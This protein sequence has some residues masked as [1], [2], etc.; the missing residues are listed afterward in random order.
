MRH[1][2]LC[3][4]LAFVQLSLIAPAMGQDEEP[5][6]AQEESKPKDIPYLSGMPDFEITEN[7]DIEFDSYQ[8]FDGKNIVP[9]EGRLYKRTY[10]LKDGAPGVSELQIRRNYISA[11]K[12]MG[13]AI[14]YEG[15]CE[16][17]NDTRS[18][19]TLVWGKV[20]RNSDELWVEVYP[21]GGGSG[22]SYSLAVL[23]KETMKQD[24]TANDMF[25]ALNTDGHIAL[26]INFDVNKSTI[27]PDSRSIIAQIVAMLKANPD[28]QISIEGHTDNT[29][30]AQ[31]NKTLSEQ[32]AQAVR[33]AITAENIDAARLA[34]V[35]WG[36]EKPVADNKSED[37]RAKNRRV[38]LVKK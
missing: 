27:R 4:A 34:T 30:T 21:Q 8:F 23:L 22:A 37:G 14:L 29:G 31:R 7:E 25:K 9:V 33:D 20:V 12:S 5:S 35:G 28:L 38:E 17:F 19:G 13:A 36:Q 10:A 24:V 2:T 6:A 26:Y 11:L 32:R 16:D 3:T 15:R 18:M 1:V